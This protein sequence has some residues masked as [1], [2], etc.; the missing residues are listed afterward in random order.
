MK[1]F[2]HRG[3]G[4]E[5][6]PEDRH[7]IRGEVPPVR[8]RIYHP[9][10]ERGL[11]PTVLGNG[12]WEGVDILHQTACNLAG[13][14]I[15]IVTFD[16]LRDLPPGDNAL[17]QRQDTLQAVVMDVAEGY[18]PV[19]VVAH[20][21]D[22]ITTTYLGELLHAAGLG[23]IMPSVTLVAGAGL[24]QS[25][26]LTPAVW[27]GLQECAGEILHF[28]KLLKHL[29]GI[30]VGSWLYAHN[31]PL[32]RQEAREALAADVLPTLAKLALHDVDVT[33]LSCLNDQLF[34][35]VAAEQR[36]RQALAGTPVRFESVPAKHIDFPMGNEALLARIE[37]SVVNA[38]ERKLQISPSVFS[39][40]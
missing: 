27:A 38:Y 20:S 3:A 30:S 5:A 26:E 36:A 11:P 23:E 17:M 24:L 39:V 25:H 35:A 32:A 7:I 33:V 6:A 13:R 10:E 29:G 21:T 16:H 34:S 37:E 1:L 15:R 12:W 40:S 2:G 4:Y 9:A 14:G 18:G 31:L 28:Q 8:M 22:A 19:H